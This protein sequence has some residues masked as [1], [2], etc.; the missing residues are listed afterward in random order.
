[1]LTRKMKWIGVLAVA[2]CMTEVAFAQSGG[3]SL[4]EVGSPDQ[5][6]SGAGRAARAKDASTAYGNPA[7]M[8]WMEQGQ[9]LLGLGVGV[10]TQSLKLDSSTRPG[11]GGRRQV[12]NGKNGGGWCGPVVP[13]MGLYVVQP[14]GDQFAVGLAMN[15]PWGGAAK[16]DK[17][18]AARTYCTDGIWM[19]MN[20]EPTFSWRPVEWFGIGVGV[21]FVYATLNQKFMLNRFESSPE[22]E[23]RKADDWGVGLTFGIMV[24]PVKGTRIGVRYSS[25]VDLEL[26]G[27]LVTRRGKFGSKSDME[28]PQSVTVALHQRLTDDLTL[29][30]DVGWTDWSRFSG[31]PTAVGDAT[32]P[33]D[34]EWR[35]TW[36]VGVGLEWDINE[37]WTL[38]GGYSYDTDPIKDSMRRPDMPA[39]E[40]HRWSVGAD[41]HIDDHQTVSLSYTFLW[42]GAMEVDNVVLSPDRAREVTID[43]KYDPAAFHF[44]ALNYSY[45]W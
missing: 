2:I 16:Y 28:L 12:D 37:Q 7:G 32:I 24:E 14:I 41:Y 44:I 3:V 45:T 42:Q 19:G 6:M 39:G 11:L 17:D 43:G 9:A 29:L 22:I 18:W 23:I 34:R 10:G 8:G 31:M 5:G 40:A 4:T 20:F 33:I 30:A 13:L 36:H 27:H 26:D 35:D 15:A 21:N 1:M 38:R 25:K